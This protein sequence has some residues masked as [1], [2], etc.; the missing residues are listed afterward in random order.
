MADVGEVGD[1]GDA[2]FDGVGVEA[3]EGGAE[4]DVF[5]AGEFGVEAGA[6]FEQCGDAAAGME[7]AFRWVEDAGHHLKESGF[8]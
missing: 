3:E 4:A 7:D 1:V 5:A 2:R 6:E 8:A